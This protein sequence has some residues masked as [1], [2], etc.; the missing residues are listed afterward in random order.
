MQKS[1]HQEN[2]LIYWL[3]MKVG[4]HGGFP[5]LDG[6]YWRV[7]PYFNEWYIFPAPYGPFDIESRIIKE[8]DEYIKQKHKKEDNDINII[9]DDIMDRINSLI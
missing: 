9:L 5:H 6:Y 3:S 7:P 1:H 2:D 8:S 4:V